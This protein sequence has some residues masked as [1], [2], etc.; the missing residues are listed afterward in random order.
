MH[1]Y[2][3]N[4]LLESNQRPASILLISKT[5]RRKRSDLGKRGFGE[6]MW[7]I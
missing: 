2:H 1:H 4:S 3:Q 6:K 5:S 7:D